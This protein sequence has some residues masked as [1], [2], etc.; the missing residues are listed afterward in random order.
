MHESVSLQSAIHSGDGQT[1]SGS[2]S[3]LLILS[4]LLNLCREIPLSEPRFSRD[5]GTTPNSQT[6]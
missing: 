1:A 2:W 4:L 5:G 6:R 3:L